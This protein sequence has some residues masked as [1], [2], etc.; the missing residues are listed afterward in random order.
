MSDSGSAFRFGLF[1]ARLFQWISAVIVLGLTAWAT[2]HLDGYRVVYT[3]VIAALTTAFYIPAFFLSFMKSNRGYMLPMDVV[4]SYLWLAAFIFLSQANNTCSWFVWT[5]SR[6]CARKNA[7]EAFTFLAFFWT[8]C[9]MCLEAG[10]V[11]YYLRD[12]RGAGPNPGYI[13]K[14]RPGR[15]GSAPGSQAPDGDHAAV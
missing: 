12:A 13:E 9:G 3:L 8:L 15:N 5:A 1:F 2:V 4:F 6:A 10:N 14:H 11:Y 7:A